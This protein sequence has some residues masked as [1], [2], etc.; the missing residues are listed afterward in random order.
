MQKPYTSYN[1]Y[2][3][4]P[5]IIWVIA[6]GIALS[7][8]DARTL[9]EAVNGHYTET[10]DALMRYVTWMGE[11]IF[12]AVVLLVLLGVSAFRNWWYFT[13]AV[14]TNAFPPLVIQMVKSG[15][16]APRPLKF[17]NNAE[18]IHI[19]PQWPRLLERSFP[20]GHTCA[21]F[22]LFTFLAFLLPAKHKAWGFV[23]FLLGI[24]VAYSR[25]YLAAHFFADVYAGSIIGVIF[26]MAVMAIMRHYQPRFFKNKATAI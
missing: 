17:F 23:F 24:M 26:I 12:S 1:L 21:A 5:F 15:V 2:F 6:G 25:L 10:G 19:L 11:G 20:S 3:L 4:V 22:C 8:Y 7:V 13:C 9:F 14:L 18:W 16:G